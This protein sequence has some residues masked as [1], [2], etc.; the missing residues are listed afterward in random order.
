MAVLEQIDRNRPQ[1][2]DLAKR[3]LQNYEAT[4]LNDSTETHLPE[5]TYVPLV[6]TQ[7]NLTA[8]VDNHFSEPGL[9]TL[10]LY[11]G[12]LT[13][14]VST[15]VCIPNHEMYQVWLHLF[16]RV[17][18][19]TKMAEKSSNY[20]RGAMIRELWSGETTLLSNMAISSHGVLSNHNNFV[21]KDYAN[22]AAKTTIAVSRFGMLTH[23][24][25]RS[26]E[27]SQIVPVCENHAGTGR[28][29]YSMHLYSSK[30]KPN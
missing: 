14:W 10:F 6:S 16:A 21:E 24:Q 13:R 2:I 29:D 30:N 25:Q 15:S 12:Y 17:V 8:S 22:H 19:G 28:C 27:L 11:A 7:V 18:M 4:K 23:L 9:L 20:K 1:F 3:L 26:V 5:P